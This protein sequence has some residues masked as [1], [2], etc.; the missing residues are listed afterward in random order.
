MCIFTD[1]VGHVGDTQIFA[2]STSAT[3]QGLIYGMSFSAARTLAM[4]LPIPVASGVPEDD[5]HFI[6]LKDYGDIFERCR[7]PFMSDRPR[8]RDTY[9]DHDDHPRLTLAV[10]AV[11]D[12]DASFVPTREDFDRLDPRFRLAPD[13]WRRL[14]RYDDYGFVVLKLQRGAWQVHPIGLAFT[15]RDPRRLFFPTTHVHHGS[16]SRVAKFDHELFTQNV[17]SRALTWRRSKRTTSSVSFDGM[18]LLRED[19]ETWLYRKTIRGPR[20]NRDV[21]L[22]CADPARPASETPAIG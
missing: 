14:D 18:P 5:V 17:P 20:F 6:A 19:D 16:V 11:G 2:C 4:V 7:M 1:E 22:N 8:K 15:R 9:D 21:W 3:R 13:V 10:H 12:Y